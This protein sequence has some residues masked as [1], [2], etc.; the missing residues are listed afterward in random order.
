[1]MPMHARTHARTYLGPKRPRRELDDGVVGQLE[2]GQLLGG[3]AHEV[4]VQA[5]LRCCGLVGWLLCGVY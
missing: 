2:V 5:P 3:H 4:G 1:M